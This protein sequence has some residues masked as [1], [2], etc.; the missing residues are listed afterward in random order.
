MSGVFPVNWGTKN[1][2]AELGGMSVNEEKQTGR[3]RLART[4]RVRD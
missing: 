1:D 4:E 2:G 3:K